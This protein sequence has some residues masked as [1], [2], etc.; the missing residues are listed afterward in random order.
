MFLGIQTEKRCVMIR[1]VTEKTLFIIVKSL[2]SPPLLSLSKPLIES[3]PTI[4]AAHQYAVDCWALQ[5]AG[6]ETEGGKGRWKRNY[7]PAVLVLVV[8]SSVS[9]RPAGWD[10]Y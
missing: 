7:P 6:T 2:T 4:A 9:W 5:F 1:Q 10:A 8:L 3:P